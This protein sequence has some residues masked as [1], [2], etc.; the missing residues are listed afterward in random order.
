MQEVISQPTTRYCNLHIAGRSLSFD[1]QSNI[2]DRVPV[3]PCHLTPCTDHDAR[4]SELQKAAFASAAPVHDQCILLTINYSP[5]I[6]F[7]YPPVVSCAC[8]SWIITGQLSTG[9]LITSHDRSSFSIVFSTIDTQKRFSLVYK[10]AVCIFF[11]GTSC[12][13]SLKYVA[14]ILRTTVHALPDKTCENT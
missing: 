10:R 12:L 8:A 1:T 9:C 6:Y 11:P 3:N 5:N 7:S 14:N 13:N 4:A 2:D